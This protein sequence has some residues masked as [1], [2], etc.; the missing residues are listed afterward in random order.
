MQVK[1]FKLVNGDEV[2]S[3]YKDDPDIRRTLFVN[4]AKVVTIP[5]EDG[6]MAMALVPWCLFSNNEEFSIDNSHIII[7]V[8]AP[9]ELYNEYNSKFGPGITDSTKQDIIY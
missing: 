3:E 7:S 6:G 1:I 2:I 4:P 9:N 8:D 5:T